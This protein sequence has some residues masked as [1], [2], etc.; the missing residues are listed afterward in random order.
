MK[1]AERL[2][3]SIFEAAF[4]GHLTKNNEFLDVKYSNKFINSDYVNAIPESWVYKSI[5]ECFIVR[6]GFTP[7]R[8]VAKY[9]NSKDIPWMTVT[10]INLNGDV[11]YKTEQWI[12]KEATSDNRIVPSESILICCTSATIGRVAKNI[13]PLTT[14]QQFNALTVRDNMKESILT[15]YIFYWAKTLKPQLYHL[16]GKTTF[17]FLSTSKLKKFGFPLP[18]LSEQKQIVK[19][20]DQI[21]PMI[22]ALE[23][24]EN[25]LDEIVSQFPDK[26]KA[27]ILQAAIQGKLTD[28]LPEDGNAEDELRK[29]LG[30]QYKATTESDY[31]FEI[32]ENWVW[33]KLGDV[34]D[35]SAG[36]TPKNSFITTQKTITPFYK[37][38]DMNTV[39]NFKYM[40]SS[41]NYIKVDY[42]GKLVPKNSVI[43]PKNGGAVFTN[44]RRITLK[45][46]LVDLNTGYSHSDMLDIEY[47]YWWFSTI[48]FKQIYSGTALPTV[49]STKV[50][51][52]LIPVPPLAEQKRVVE[53][54]NE[55]LPIINSLTK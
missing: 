55:I 48:D 24:D 54:I 16:S 42:R 26:M 7:N 22:D 9:W 32:P 25:I 34:S 21:L 30:K 13:I 28:Q 50:S 12:S 47:L 2:K 8:S 37:V 11:I 36:A 53:K 3:A 35:V 45:E 40:A 5:D 20:L 46:S 19:K 10:D 51:S 6:N 14:N 29:Y 31:P 43:Y 38:S 41:N 4:D 23:K 44:K 33:Q 39:E 17:P 18:P 15:D 49:S 27:S 1:L 52:M